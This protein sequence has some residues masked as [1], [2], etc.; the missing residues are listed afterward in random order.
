MRQRRSGH[1]G[2]IRGRGHGGIGHGGGG[3]QPAG[4]ARN[5]GRGREPGAGEARGRGRGVRQHVARVHGGGA[6]GCGVAL[7]GG[8]QR[9]RGGRRGCGDGNDGLERRQQ[10]LLA[11]G[12]RARGAG[13]RAGVGTGRE[14]GDRARDV[15][16]QHVHIHAGGQPRRQQRRGRGVRAAQHR[17]GGRGHCSVG[18]SALVRVQEARA[19]RGGL[20]AT[21]GSGPQRAR[22]QRSGHARLGVSVHGALERRRRRHGS[23]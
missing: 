14:L 3:R 17:R 15:V 4:E 1:G 16:E 11:C 20:T 22:V 21:G 10:R 13:A 18:D 19:T 2:A 7:G 8:A 9:G 23:T 5:A 12:Q 6:R